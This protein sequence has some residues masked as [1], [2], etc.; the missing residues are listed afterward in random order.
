M[1]V[2]GGQN[3]HT[4]RTAH[5]GTLQRGREG[6][7]PCIEPWCWCWYSCSPRGAIARPPCRCP[8]SRAWAPCALTPVARQRC[9]PSSAVHPMT[10]APSSVRR[11]GGAI[12]T[13]IPRTAARPTSRRT[14][15]TAAPVAAS[16][17]RERGASSV[18][19]SEPGFAARGHQNPSAK[20]RRAVSELPPLFVTM[21]WSQSGLSGVLPV[22][23]VAGPVRPVCVHSRL[24]TLSYASIVN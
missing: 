21:K 23:N 14:P 24:F 11:A 17:P 12:A 15:G 1:G 7:L 4:Q 5:G 8:S 18:G 20:L 9:T 2:Q 10:R 16:A 13:A 22:E 3:V 6:V 19:A